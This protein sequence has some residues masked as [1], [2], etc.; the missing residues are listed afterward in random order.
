MAA[1]TD[2]TAVTVREA[3]LTDR[4]RRRERLLRAV[5]DARAISELPLGRI[6]C[7]ASVRELIEA[8]DDLARVSELEALLDAI[9]TE[10]D[11]FSD[12]A[13]SAVS[14]AKLRGNDRLLLGHGDIDL[15]L[16]RV[17]FHGTEAV[18]P[19]FDAVLRSTDAGSLRMD[20]A[21]SAERQSLAFA[22]EFQFIVDGTPN[23]IEGHERLLRQLSTTRHREDYGLAG[24]LLLTFTLGV[25]LRALWG[26]GTATLTDER[27][28]G[29]IFDEDMS[30]RPRCTED[31]WMPAAGVC[32]D[33]S[34]VIVFDIPREAIDE[35]EVLDAG[36]VGTR[37]PY[38]NL[39][40]SA[41]SLACQ[42]LR[43]FEFDRLVRPR[44]DVLGG[45][46]RAF[47]CADSETA[48]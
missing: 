32:S 7:L 35:V 8:S 40:G 36:F 14:V 9:D 22:G 30:G 3:D 19:E 2:R 5:G 47:P 34:S 17:D 23:T 13:L 46:L 43:V 12:A 42:T 38:A 16:L 29:V 21:L 27:M 10:I 44:K 25:G 28:L 24:R 20:P 41:F 26:S 15:R 45:A 39:Y 31:A 37:I 33:V 1:E 48:P 18:V 11:G 4:D 6:D